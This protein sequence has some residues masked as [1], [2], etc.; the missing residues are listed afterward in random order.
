VNLKSNNIPNDWAFYLK[1]EFYKS[2]FL[3]LEKFLRQEYHNYQCFPP[4]AE[5]FNAFNSCLF[6]D[7]NVVIIG[8]DPYH[9]AQQAHGLCFSVNQGI[10]HPPSLI[11]IF[12]E[13]ENDIGK[14]YPKS[15]DLTSWAKQGVL[16]LNTTLTVRFNE[17][18]SHQKKGWET[19]TNQVIKCISHNHEK[20]VFLL[21]GGLAKKKSR[22]IDLNKHEV[23]ISGHPSPLSAN[24]GYWFGNKH[25]SKT[26]QLLKCWGKPPINW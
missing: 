23:L 13:L 2:Y 4:E 17:A 8:Q 25:F 10:S 18:K 16:L 22:L 21:W 12:K 5:I 11:N 1:N 15:G 9:G 3:A 19:F 7:L 20:V 26:N 24:R 14:P 6:Q